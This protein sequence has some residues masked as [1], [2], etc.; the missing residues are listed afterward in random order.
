MKFIWAIKIISTLWPLVTKCASRPVEGEP[1][2]RQKGLS[3]IDL[4]GMLLPKE[5]DRDASTRLMQHSNQSNTAGIG[6]NYFL[7]LQTIETETQDSDSHLF[8]KS[9]SISK[10]GSTLAVTGSLVYD[11]QA[12]EH[13][14]FVD[15]YKVPSFEKIN[16]RIY[17]DVDLSAPSLNVHLNDDGT[18]LAIAIVYQRSFNEEDI[19]SGVEVWHLVSDEYI[20]ISKPIEVSGESGDFPG[21]K[22]SL[23]GDGE[24]IVIGGQYYDTDDKGQTTVFRLDKFSLWQ[25]IGYLEGDSAGDHEGS[26]VSMTSDGAY[27][28]S[29]ATGFDTDGAGDNHGAVRIYDVSAT[30]Q[31]G[32]TI[33][34]EGDGDACGF[35]VGLVMPSE[36]MLRVA[37]GSIYND[38]SDKTSNAGHVRV[39]DYNIAAGTDSTWSIVGTEMNGE[40]GFSLDFD[41]GFYHIGQ[42]FGFSLALSSKGER[43]AIGSPYYSHRRE[44]EYYYGHVKL[45]E[46]DESASDWV[47]LGIDVV[48]E[49]GRLASGYSVDLTGD[50]KI[51]AIGGQAAE[52]ERGQ[53]TIEYQSEIS[54]HPSLSPSLDPSNKP[55]SYPSNKPSSYPTVSQGPSASPSAFSERTFMIMSTLNSFTAFDDV[56]RSWCLETS[57]RTGGSTLKVRPCNTSSKNQFWHYDE[58]KLVLATTPIPKNFCIKDEAKDLVLRSCDRVVNSFYFGEGVTDGEE[59]SIYVTRENSQLKK[60]FFG[61]DTFKIFSRI[62]LFREGSE[63]SSAWKWKLSFYQQEVIA[64]VSETPSITPTNAPIEAHSP[65][66]T[67]SAPTKA[68]IK[69]PT[70]IVSEAPTGSPTIFDPCKTYTSGGACKKSP[71]NCAWGKGVC[72]LASPD[73][74]SSSNCG[75][76]ANGGAC[77]KAAGCQWQKSICK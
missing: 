7:H 54:D 71:S 45:Y 29:G 72:S 41:A 19:D 2:E 43:V 30:T 23:S 1:K 35:S 33:T 77:K 3:S 76:C 25:K 12:G 28:A 13:K 44:S 4:D 64:A 10:D 6:D 62:R 26:S 59:G 14:G 74:C 57:S 55:S 63:N 60:R 65:A 73:S 52:G 42:A 68:P 8:G 61:I 24:V 32:N 20:P 50:G 53:L 56:T 36:S 11:E 21:L 69:A 48:G 16:P 34:G 51:L 67:T 40:N 5:T 70:R 75:L 46:Y 38:P 27:F 31:I 47:Q 49:N 37:V 18:R 9:L 22:V 58:R 39:Y 17:T 15:I 66:P